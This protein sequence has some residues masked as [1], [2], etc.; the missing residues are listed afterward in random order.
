MQAVAA[1]RASRVVVAVRGIH[2]VII[3]AYGVS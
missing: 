2:I 3:D 1:S